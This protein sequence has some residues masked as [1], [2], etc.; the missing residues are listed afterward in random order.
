MFFFSKSLNFRICGPDTKKRCAVRQQHA[1]PHLGL[2]N[3][4]EVM[5]SLCISVFRYSNIQLLVL[6]EP[7]LPSLADEYNVKC[8]LIYFI[9]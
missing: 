2:R 8:S 9:L 4:Y 6:Y 1:E 3:D 7:S 5:R